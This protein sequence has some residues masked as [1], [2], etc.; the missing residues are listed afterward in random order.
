MYVRG[1][2]R[3]RRAAPGPRPD[4]LARTHDADGEGRKR[5]SHARRSANCGPAGA[6]PAEQQHLRRSRA[7]LCSSFSRSR[8]ARGVAPRAPRAARA[9]RAR[10]PTP[11]PTPTTP[12]RRLQ[13]TQHRLLQVQRSVQHLIAPSLLRDPD[14]LL[15]TSF[16]AKFYR[17]ARPVPRR[18]RRA[19]GR[20]S[21]HRDVPRKRAGLKCPNTSIGSRGFATGAA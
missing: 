19:I 10:A 11:A 4:Q 2:S 7:T 1:L 14:T 15:S 13:T 6:S 5:I 16:S 8:A 12:S 17:I 21:C 3:V 18:A 20:E 9:A